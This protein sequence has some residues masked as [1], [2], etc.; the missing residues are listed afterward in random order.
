MESFVKRK[1]NVRIIANKGSKEEKEINL[2]GL[3]CSVH[4]IHYV[5]TIQGQLRL[6]I[7]GM[8]LEQMDGLTVFGPIMQERRFNEITVS[9][10]DEGGPMPIVYSG[11]IYEAYADI[12]AAPNVRFSIRAMSAAADQVNIVK[13]R[14]HKG[15]V[16]AAVILA[17]LAKEMG[18]TFEN[19]GVSVVLQNRT[20]NGTALTQA[21]EV[22]RDANIN[23]SIDRGIL[24]IWPREGYRDGD[25]IEV[26]SETGMVGYPVFSG[27]GV[28]CT[29]I[30]NPDI[31]CGRAVEV[32][33]SMKVASGKWN[34]T[35]VNHFLE[36]EVAGGAWFTQIA[37][38]G[39]PLQ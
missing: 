6:Q 9:A 1:I 5:G 11:C 25:P 4:A 15:G 2:E 12:N 34:V 13:S 19:N 27:N 14:S 32:K 7:W 21:I 17:D 35:R 18:K 31:D 10:G 8:S 29:T 33:S 38:Y 24:A 26:S 22:A 36:S 23:I 30:F 3:R 39:R 20:Y 16:D 37:T 28:V